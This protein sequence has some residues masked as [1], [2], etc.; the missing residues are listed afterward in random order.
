MFRFDFLYILRYLLLNFFVY[1][2]NS[3]II[4]TIFF[5]LTI[6]IY[7]QINQYHGNTKTCYA[8]NFMGY[9][10]ASKLKKI[11]K[12]DYQYKENFLVEFI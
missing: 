9:L 5:F 2:C 8:A 3:L 7:I 12:T 1:L 11:L 4:P 6:Y 10:I